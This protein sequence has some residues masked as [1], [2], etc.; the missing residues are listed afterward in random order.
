MEIIL[1]EL[2]TKG[3]AIVDGLKKALSAVRTTRPNAAL[4]EDLKA[5][6][7][8]QMTP[9]KQ[10]G[11]ISVQ[12]PREISIQVWDKAAVPSVAKAI[13]SSTLN[14]SANIDGQ[15]IRIFLPELSQER[16]DELIKHIK[17]VTEEHK[18]QI[19][20][21]RDEIN[22]KIQ[23]AFD[24]NELNEDQKFKAKELT[25]K[26]VDKLNGEIDNILE[27]KTKEINE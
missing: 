23:I 20:H 13:E 24:G 4:V 6:Y 18:I 21:L 2:K 3:Q 26:E 9:V 16:R 15:V 5:N 11:T 17:K 25:Q 1:N 8:N 22:K 12:P 14:L 7:Y 19:R 27:N 10:L